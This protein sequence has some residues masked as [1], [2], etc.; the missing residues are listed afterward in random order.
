MVI[1]MVLFLDT[2]ISFKVF[3]IFKA[4]NESRPLV[5]SSRNIIAGSVTNSTAIATRFRSPP[6]IPRVLAFP[7]GE[8]FTFTSPNSLIVS[9]TTCFRCL[10]VKWGSL[11]SALN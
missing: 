4:I 3:M 1:M 2:A 11:R 9:S 7:M 5:G 10:D 8:F 6:L